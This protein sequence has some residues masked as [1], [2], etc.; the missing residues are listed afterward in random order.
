MPLI[1][2]KIELV[3][4]VKGYGNLE[5]IEFC[6]GPGQM[7]RYKLIYFWTKFKFQKLFALFFLLRGYD[8]VQSTEG[9]SHF[10][11]GT[12]PL[13]GLQLRNIFPIYPD[14]QYQNVFHP[15]QNPY[16]LRRWEYVL[17]FSLSFFF[18]L[19]FATVLETYDEGI[20]A[21]G[22]FSLLMHRRDVRDGAYSQHTY[23]T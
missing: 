23:G 9:L 10:L 12:D 16:I 13:A 18:S 4:G 1:N 21:Q 3:V 6:D 5:M 2:K 22:K 19:S 17:Y 14:S 20:A 11:G 15:S 8:C 7:R